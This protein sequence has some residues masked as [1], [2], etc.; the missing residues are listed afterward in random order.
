MEFNAEDIQD[1]ELLEET[2]DNIGPDRDIDFGVLTEEI[3]F[4]ELVEEEY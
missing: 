4:E 3:E 1:V 2:D